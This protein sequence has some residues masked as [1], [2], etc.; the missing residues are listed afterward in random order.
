MYP[1][2]IEVRPIIPPDNEYGSEI[3]ALMRSLWDEDP[4]KR[5]SLETAESVVRSCLGKRYR[6]R[7]YVSLDI[8]RCSLASVAASLRT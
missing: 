7:T 1:K 4:R 2:G 5:P 8:E 6:T 3:A